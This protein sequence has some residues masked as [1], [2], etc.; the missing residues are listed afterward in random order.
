MVRYAEFSRAVDLFVRGEYYFSSQSESQVHVYDSVKHLAFGKKVS[1]RTDEFIIY[2]LKLDHLINIINKLGLKKDYWLTVISDEKPYILN[3]RGY[4]IKSN[5]FLM[6]LN[7]DSWP[8]KT[9]NKIIRRVKNKGEACRINDFFDKAVIDLEK[10][11]EPNLRF[12]VGEENG[13]PVSYG[14]Y[15]LLEKTVF[16]NNVFTSKMYRGQGIAK[17]LCQNMLID[18]KREG[19]NQSVLVSSQMGHSLYQKLGYRD[20]SKMWVYERKS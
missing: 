7:L 19:A 14:S 3:E 9:E 20:V 18:A 17:A 13:N 10:W 1:G 6:D 11:N 16:L 2:Y 5:E 8:F 15:A 12:Y 4:T